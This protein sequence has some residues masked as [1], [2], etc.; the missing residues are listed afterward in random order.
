MT[1]TIFHGIDMIRKNL[2]YTFAAA[3]MVVCSC[4]DNKSWDDEPSIFTGDGDKS[5]NLLATPYTRTVV[6]QE[7]YSVEWTAG[8]KVS[9]LDGQQNREFVTV[10][11]GSMAKFSGYASAACFHTSE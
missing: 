3:L 10:D 1:R 7:D 8:D 2:K 5:F 4:V 9:L 6:S 11:G